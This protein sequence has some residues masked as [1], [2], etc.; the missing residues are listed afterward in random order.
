[1]EN[2]VRRAHEA[3]RA[4]NWDDLRLLLHPYLHWASSDGRT[5]RG[6]TNVMAM[7]GRTR[8]AAVADVR[9]GSGRSN[10][11]LAGA[12]RLSH[13]MGSGLTRRSAAS[14]AAPT[15]PA[16]L[17]SLAGTISVFSFNLGMNLS[18]FLLTPPPTTIKSG[19]SRASSVS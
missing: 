8:S 16:L 15:M 10:L 2:V 6:R 12:T 3:M 4:R 13:I 9:R 11:S 1:M 17:R 14:Q 7:L 5:V 18:A 19:Q